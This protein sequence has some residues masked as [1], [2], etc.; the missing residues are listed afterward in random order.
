MT[1]RDNV[2][3]DEFAADEF[4]YIVEIALQAGHIHALA[5]TE[6]DTRRA[7]NPYARAALAL[8][9]YFGD[10]KRRFESAMS[11]FVALMHLFTR[12]RLRAWVRASPTK[13][14]T[15]DIHPAVIHT[16]AQMK[17]NQNRKFPER[18]FLA[19]VAQLAEEHYRELGDWKAHKP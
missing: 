11:R 2:E 15:S 6:I 10:D 4:G 19:V 18:K 9:D 16:A 8:Q 17:L 7:R 12:G 14:D 3:D 5:V 1:A 13:T